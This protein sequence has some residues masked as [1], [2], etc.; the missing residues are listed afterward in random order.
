ML[1]IIGLYFSSALWAQSSG[2][3]SDTNQSWTATTDSHNQSSD[4]I[5]TVESHTQSGNRTVDKQLVQRRASDGSYVPYQDVEKETVQ[6]DA[7]TVR[8]ITRTF[9]HNANGGR[10]LVEVVEE[11]R[12]ASGGDSNVVR[13]TSRPDGNGNLRLAQRQIE[14]T[15]KISANTEDVKT[16]VMIPGV[17]GV[18]VP[19]AK[20]DERRE[21][22]ANGT[23]E[24]KKTTL[25]PDGAGNWRVNEVRRSTIAQDG[26]SR[27]TDERVAVPDSEGKLNEVSRTVS[28]ASDM[29][30]G[31]KYDAIDTYSVQMPGAVEDGNL[32]LVQRAVTAQHTNASGQQ[33]TE[34]QT[35]EPN[36]GDPNAG[37]RI[38]T[39]TFDTV[40]PGASGAQATRTVQTRDLN[41]NLGVV[42][43]DTAKSDNIHAIQV[44]IAPAAA[45]KAESK[46][47]EPTGNIPK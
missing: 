14:E 8:T 16:T 25:L 18:L 22:G 12:S 32:H 33:V 42:S 17:D 26:D 47:G 46:P 37:L 27:S 9:D 39:V 10:T 23:V 21:Q 1:L 44:Q 4:P 13:S 3:T 38:T 30:P 15:K 29:A 19:S 6:L 24:S 35:A 40:G 7:G 20:I 41:G 11:K 5:R 43:F 36:P 45:P 34:Q 31:E 2:S 28:K